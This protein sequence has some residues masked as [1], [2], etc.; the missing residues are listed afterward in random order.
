MW[1]D[2]DFVGIVAVRNGMNFSKVKQFGYRKQ[3]QLNKNTVY[4]GPCPMNHCKNDQN[5]K[6][7]LLNYSKQ[8][9][10]DNDYWVI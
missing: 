1:S 8:L 7:N 3:Q 10:W 2:N 6:Q 9:N 4:R 5:K